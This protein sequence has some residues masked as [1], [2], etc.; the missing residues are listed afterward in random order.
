MGGKVAARR[1]ASAAECRWYPARFAG[2]IGREMCVARRQQLGY[3]LAIK[4]VGGG[5]GR[6]LRVVGAASDAEAAFDSA[7]REAQCSLQ[8]PKLYVEKY[9]DDP[10]H[11]EI[12]VLADATAMSSTSASAIA[13]SSAGIRS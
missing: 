1:E 9:L 5:G 12:Q 2:R 10:R 3:P 6:G 4:A 11:I 8:N 13:R 7:R